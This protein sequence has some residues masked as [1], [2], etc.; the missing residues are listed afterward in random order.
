MNNQA[1]LKCLKYPYKDAL[2]RPNLTQSEINGLLD[3]NQAEEVRFSFTPFT[4]KTP[5]SEKSELRIFV[6]QFQ[7]ESLLLTNVTLVIQVIVNNN[8]W[9]M[10]DGKVRP[11]FMI[12]EILKSLNQQ[13][14]EMVGLLNFDSTSRVVNY[15]E[16]FA[17]YELYP[18][19]RSV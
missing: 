18:S 12:S 1:L 2:S 19:V 10:D 3:N 8:L 7:P 5:E 6:K 9:L 4:Y 13:E 17:G 11:L 16:F 14:I 15:N